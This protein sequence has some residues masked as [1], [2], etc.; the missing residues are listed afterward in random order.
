MALFPRPSSPL[1]AWRD[2]RAFFATRQRHQ[3]LFAGISIA[4]PLLFVAAFV[5]D[6]HFDPPPP[7]MYF[8][9]SW[10]LT[11][12]DAEIKT[13]QKIDQAAKDKALAERRAEFQRLADQLGIKEDHRGEPKR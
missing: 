7:E 11:R 5:H 6:S 2:L 1:R 8:I 12:T 3:L 9:P 13:Q 10:P 4:I